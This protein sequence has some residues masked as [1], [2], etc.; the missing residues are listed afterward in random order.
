MALGGELPHRVAI[1]VHL[2]HRGLLGIEMGGIAFRQFNG[3]EKPVVER[4]GH[5]SRILL[6]HLGQ[7][8]G[9]AALE[10][11]LH[12][13]FWR[14]AAAPF[15]GHFHQ[16]PIAIPGVVE[17]VVADVDVF[18]AVFAQG[19]TK[20][21]AGATQPGRDQLR[22]V[23]PLEAVLAFHQHAQLDQAIEPDAQ[24]VLVAALT[25]AE[26]LFKL[27]KGQGFIGRKLVEQVGDR[28]LHRLGQLVG[29]GPSQ[30]PQRMLGSIGLAGVGPVGLGSERC[31]RPPGRSTSL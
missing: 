9:G 2:H 19:K 16:H 12:A 6:I 30:E 15:A 3:G 21:F 1:E 5:Q 26:G 20:P 17:L 11:A 28:E 25:Q 13:P 18:A 7:Q 10:N 4:G 8:R 27:G 22:V 23:A 14:A 29:G 31:P 24:L